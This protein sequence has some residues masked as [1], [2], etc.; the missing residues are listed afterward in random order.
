MFYRQL[1][2]PALA[3]HI[4]SS[5][6]VQSFAA[7]ALSLQSFSLDRGLWNQSL[8]SHM[9]A[10]WFQDLPENATHADPVT[11]PSMRNWYD[12]FP[13]LELESIL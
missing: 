7:M 12:S 11:S 9:R 6:R 8:Y 5:F 4:T 10:F 13:F 2:R 3:I 1:L